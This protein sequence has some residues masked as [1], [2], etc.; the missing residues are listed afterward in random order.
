MS[1]KEFKLKIRWYIVLPFLLVGLTIF[2]VSVVQA[3]WAILEDD[4]NFDRFRINP[5][6]F[7]IDGN[8][9]QTCRV[10]YNLPQVSHVSGQLFYPIKRLRDTI[11]LNLSKQK[12][13]EAKMLL[14]MADKKIAELLILSQNDKISKKNMIDSAKEAVDYLDKANVVANQMDNV[15]EAEKI[16]DKLRLAKYFY[17][18][19]FKSIGE[20]IDEKADYGELVEKVLAIEVRNND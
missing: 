16:R 18:E 10:K 17:S 15:I 9:G 19:V 2:A 12:G 11:W 7:E 5:V 20:V 8:E 13:N 14:L 1:P 3:S 4:K 6:E